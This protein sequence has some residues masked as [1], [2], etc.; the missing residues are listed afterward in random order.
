MTFQLFVGNDFFLTDMNLSINL[1]IFVVSYLESLFGKEKMV[2][3]VAMGIK[4]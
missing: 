4:K 1:K 2:E 3:F